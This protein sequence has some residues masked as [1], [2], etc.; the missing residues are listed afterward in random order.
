MIRVD[1]HRVGFSGDV[2]TLMAEYCMLTERLI[3]QIAKKYGQEDAEKLIKKA[4]DDG[5][6]ASKADENE[7]LK[8]KL[9]EMIDKL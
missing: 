4:F 8:K 5:V 9:Q 1:E 2:S 3:R 6:F 7:F